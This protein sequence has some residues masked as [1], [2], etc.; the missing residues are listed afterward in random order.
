[1]FTLDLSKTKEILECGTVVEN[2]M[3]N[4]HTTLRIGGPARYFI[5]VSDEDELKELLNYFTAE[6]IPY[7]ILGNGSNILVS[8]EGYDGVIIKLDGDFNSVFVEIEK[9]EG[10]NKDGIVLEAGA[11]SLLSV[12]SKK[13][14]SASLK[15]LE[16]AAG[17]PGTVGGAVT[18]NAGAYG[19]EMKDVVKEVRALVGDGEQFVIKT[20]AG[21]NMDFS[22]R[23][24]KVKDIPM[25]VLSVTFSLHP[26]NSSEIKALMDELNQ[27]R[28]EK[29]PLMY[30][31]AGST[32]KRPEGNFAGK[33]IEEAGL[34]GYAV[35]DACVSDMHAGFCINKGS[36]SFKD[37]KQLMDYVSD[38]VYDKSGVR[39]E[40]EVIILE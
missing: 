35:G 28:K 4:N 13:A 11:A 38:T 39:L 2:E 3:M 36:A 29:Q 23:H 32:F 34:K 9:G 24:S 5:S 15:G 10:A 33:L 40:P 26:G 14:Y 7:F 30:P 22:Y 1:M 12:V 31:S 37:F 16:F 8:D 19:S 18:M 6:K 27:K 17:I 21:R 20:I 25:V